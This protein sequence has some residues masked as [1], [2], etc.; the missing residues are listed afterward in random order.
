MFRCNVVVSLIRFVT[1]NN[2]ANCDKSMKFGESTEFD[3]RNTLRV[4]NVEK[5]KEKHK[6]RVDI[7]NQH[8]ENYLLADFHFS[9]QFLFNLSNKCFFL[10]CYFRS[11]PYQLSFDHYRTFIH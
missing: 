4:V 6:F 3:M 11:A 5:R 10:L 1:G 7:R 2:R 9:L 8:D